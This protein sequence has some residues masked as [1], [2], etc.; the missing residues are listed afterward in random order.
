MRLSSCGCS[1]APEQ[2]PADGD[3]RSRTGGLAA[4][5]ETARRD[6]DGPLGRNT[7]RSTKRVTDIVGSATCFAAS[8]DG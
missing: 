5:A 1:G 3:E 7:G 4:R 6:D 8:K 2:K